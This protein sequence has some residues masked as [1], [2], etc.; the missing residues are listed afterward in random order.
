[1]TTTGRARDDLVLPVRGDTPETWARDVLRRRL[2]LLNDHAHLEKKAASNAL[3]MLH[4]WPEPNPPEH[5]VHA[6]TALARDEVEHLA[7]VTR[8]LARRGGRLTKRHAN[9]YANDLRA[10]VRTGRGR[11][12]L[13][14]RLMIA[15]LIEARSAERFD[16]LA[17]VL[18]EAERA[19]D[20]ERADPE[21]ARLYRELFVADHG[22]YRVY[23]DLAQR[24]EEA[25][26][27]A[28]RWEELLEVERELIARQTPGPRMHSGAR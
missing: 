21:L 6:M 16:V 22:H 12:E 11:A 1:M 17:R 23:L 19:G 9:P 8:I 7:V 15:A 24:V 4:R 13:V 3:E 25:A 5:W 20:D 10:L 28:P 2:P 26:A 27:V 14:D 18:D